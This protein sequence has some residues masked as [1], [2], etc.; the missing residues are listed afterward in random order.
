[1]WATDASAD[2]LATARANLAGLGRAATRVRLALGNW[3][4]ALPQELCGHIDVL[5]SNP[6][7][8][9]RSMQ[10]QMENDVLAYEPHDA[11]FS[12]DDGRDDLAKII[13]LAPLWLDPAGVLVL[14]MSPEQT[15]WA[16]EY[17]HNAGFGAVAIH[18]DFSG[19][20]R[21]MVARLV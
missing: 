19:R 15:M 21:A 11:L 6:P 5:V 18:N 10:S 8:V 7:Y 3:F 14:E 1:V 20:P 2:A 17:A 9:A 13:S 16:A 12:G 4:E